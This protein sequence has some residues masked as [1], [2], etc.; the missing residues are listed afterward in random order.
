MN[1]AELALKDVAEVITAADRLARAAQAVR[2]QPG[3]N[4]PLDFDPYVLQD[5][6]DAI[7]RYLQLTDEDH[8]Y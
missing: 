4:D 3:F 8:Q 1:K 2:E 7:D 6:S 5:L